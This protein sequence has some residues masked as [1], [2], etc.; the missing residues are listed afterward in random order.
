MTDKLQLLNLTHVDTRQDIRLLLK[1]WQCAKQEM[2]ISEGKRG[3]Q[4]Q[5]LVKKKK[6]S[7]PEILSFPF[8]SIYQQKQYCEKQ[9][10][11]LLY[12]N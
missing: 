4:I 12:S 1:C 3:T 9:L 2:V 5:V 11:Y 7:N 10:K 8:H 6:N